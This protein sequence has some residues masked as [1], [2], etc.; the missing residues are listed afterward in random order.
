MKHVPYT[1]KEGTRSKEPIAERHGLHFNHST[2]FKRGLL[3]YGDMGYMEL[4]TRISRFSV[5][6]HALVVFLRSFSLNIV[7]LSSPFLFV[8][9]FAPDHDAVRVHYGA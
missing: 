9:W 3:K 8:C 6:I 7:S 4:T 5:C 1:R 2:G